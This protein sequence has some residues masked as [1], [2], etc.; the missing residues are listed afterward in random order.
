MEVLF[1]CRAYRVGG[2]EH[3]KLLSNCSLHSIGIFTFKSGRNQQR[4][5]GTRY[6][7]FVFVDTLATTVYVHY[8]IRNF[9]LRKR[10]VIVI[11]IG[12]DGHF[13]ES[14]CAPTIERR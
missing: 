5:V 3:V 14:R 2:L 9:H 6:E 4:D 7:H 8:K 1:L 10:R 12:T 11:F 13:F